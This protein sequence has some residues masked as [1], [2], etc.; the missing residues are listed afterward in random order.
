[1]IHKLNEWRKLQLP[2]AALV[3]VALT[4]GCSS[5]K[6]DAQRD[7][8]ALEVP[9]FLS[10]PALALATNT[11][12]FTARVEIQS[13]SSLGIKRQTGRIFGLG[14]HIMFVPDFPTGLFHRE[15]AAEK[16]CFVWDATRNSGYVLN[17]ALQAYA[18]YLVTSRATNIVVT[19]AESVFAEIDGHRCLRGEAVIGMSEGPEATFTVWRA[20]DLKGFP[21]R[22]KAGTGQYTVT[23]SRVIFERVGASLFMPPDGF[24]RQD[25]P[26]AMLS[27]LMERQLAAKK[28]SYEPDENAMENAPD[29]S[30]A[31]A[32]RY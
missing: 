1:M 18:P 27:I 12:G 13:P 14:G 16:T 15:A 32:N 22:I 23:F 20:K 8:A 25:S 3:I 19:D 21:M 24:T 29:A 4:A 5:S 10:S 30:R 6:I 31:H 28:K 26:S 7:N 17:E 11:E 2:V 9:D